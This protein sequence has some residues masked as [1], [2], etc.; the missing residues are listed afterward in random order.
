M[1][2]VYSTIRFTPDAD[3]VLAGAGEFQVA[4]ALDPAT[5]AREGAA[6][7]IV[8]VRANIPAELFARAPKLARRDPPW[9]RARHD[10][11]RGGNRGRRAGRQCAGRQCTHRSPSM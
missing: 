7:D 11:G 10:P 4:S 1:S 2:I 9:R 6:A 8:I 3:E 5:L